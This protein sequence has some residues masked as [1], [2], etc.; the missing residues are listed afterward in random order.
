MGVCYGQKFEAM[1]ISLSITLAEPSGL[2]SASAR[3]LKTHSDSDPALGP[4]VGDGK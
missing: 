1:R 4:S 2:R 3:R